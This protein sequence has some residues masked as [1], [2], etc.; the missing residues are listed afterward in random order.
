MIELTSPRLEQATAIPLAATTAAIALYTRLHLPRPRDATTSPLPL[1][2]YGAG[3]AVGSFAIKL[4]VASNVHPI[5]AID[6]AGVP[7]AETLIDRSRGDTIV[8]Y[9]GSDE[10]VVKWIKGVL[11]NTGIRG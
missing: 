2:I 7:Y 4:A 6:G 3:G 1:I 9:R 8:D 11:E 5:I 10:A